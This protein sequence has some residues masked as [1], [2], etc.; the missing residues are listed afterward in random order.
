MWV[1]QFINSAVILVIINNQMSNEG[2]I[3][4]VLKIT[5]TNGI[6]FNGEYA[7]FTAEWYKVVGITIFTTSLINAVAPLFNLGMW[8]LAC[9]KRCLDRNCTCNAKKTRK[10]L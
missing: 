2:V 4:Y 7:D 1:I 10:I 5:G 9:C 8:C 3:G 6:L